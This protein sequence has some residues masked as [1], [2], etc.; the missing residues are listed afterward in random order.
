MLPQ[1]PGGMLCDAWRRALV[2]AWT[3]SGGSWSTLRRIDA[4]YLPN[5]EEVFP[6]LQEQYVQVVQFAGNMKLLDGG[7]TKSDII[8]ACFGSR[9]PER[10]S[11]REVKLTTCLCETVEE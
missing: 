7:N 4:L 11:V 3:D 1:M 9:L 2:R 5:V 8:S 10:R 6:D